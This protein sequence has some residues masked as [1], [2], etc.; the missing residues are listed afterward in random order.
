MKVLCEI[1]K[2]SRREGLYLYVDKNRGTDDLPES[3]LASF[4]T[5]QPVMTLLLDE[6]RKLARADAAEVIASISEQGYYLQ[7]PPLPAGADRDNGSE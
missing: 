7:L 6:G 1:F 2:S 3:L 5:A 4:G